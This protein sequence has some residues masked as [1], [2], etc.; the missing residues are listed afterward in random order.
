[1]SLLNMHLAGVPV[2]FGQS[3]RR[4]ETAKFFVVWIFQVYPMRSR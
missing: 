3:K 2:E 4:R 1:M